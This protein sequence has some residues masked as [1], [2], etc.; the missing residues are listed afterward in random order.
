MPHSPRTEI[1][2]EWPLLLRMSKLFADPLRIKILS[3]CH[4]REVSPKGFHEKFGEVSLDRVSRAFD[5]LAQYDWIAR[6]DARAGQSPPDPAE[7][8]YRAIDTALVDDETSAE[9][10]GPMRSLVSL[11]IFESLGDEVKRAV[12]A[13]TMENRADQHMSWT[14]LALDRLGWE[15][16][17][18][19][20]DALFYS[21]AQEQ[22]NA[23]ARL[24]ESGEEPI[25]MVVGLLGFES[26]GAGAD[27]P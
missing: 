18:S 20:V 14:P 17:I 24:S 10:P 16:V 3:E 11:R 15:A 13:G 26:P 4:V 1:E 9:I 25:S 7:Q 6:A 19:K 5:V 12:D 21:L 8:L 23:D 2:S 22:R 27:R